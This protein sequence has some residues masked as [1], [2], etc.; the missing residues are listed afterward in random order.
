MS[1]T[2]ML[3]LQQLVLENV[4]ENEEL[5]TKELLK[6]FQWLDYDDLVKLYVWSVKKFRG[7]CR[8]IIDCLFWDFDNSNY[9]MRLSPV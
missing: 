9:T 2:N 7:P 4:A 5:F 6:S 3:E 8:K 1:P